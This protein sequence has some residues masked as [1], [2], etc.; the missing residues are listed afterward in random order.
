MRHNR[1]Y[2]KNG[3]NFICYI[4][5][6]NE[7]DGN[8]TLRHSGKYFKLRIVE[9]GIHGGAWKRLILQNEWTKAEYEGV[10]FLKRL[11]MFLTILNSLLDNYKAK[12][13]R[14][15]IFHVNH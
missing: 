15:F 7:R 3:I 14:L 1:N 9:I 12:P 4:I 2:K 8:R 5:K 10:D 13:P 11:Q 6:E